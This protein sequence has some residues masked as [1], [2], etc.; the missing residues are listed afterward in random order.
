MYRISLSLLIVFAFV[1]P[2][3]AQVAER[4]DPKEEAEALRSEA[5]AFLRETMGDAANMR[6]LENRISFSAEMAGL[7][8]HVDEREARVMFNSA[9]A[10][11]RE[12]LT[13]LEYQLNEFPDEE[14]PTYRGGLLGDVSGRAKVEMKYRTAMGVR[15]QIASSIAEHDPEVALAFFYDTASTNPKRQENWMRDANFESSLIG[16][17]AEKQPAKAVQYGMRSLDRGFNYQHVEL[18]RRIYAKDPEKGA[19]FGVRIIDKIRTPETTT[20]VDFGVRELLSY[21]VT[22]LDQARN[23]PGRQPVFTEAQLREVAESYAAYMLR[24]SEKF[25]ASTALSFASTIERISPVR[26]AQLKAR[27]GGGSSNSGFGGGAPPPP[28]SRASSAANVS[29]AE[30]EAGGFGTAARPG[31]VQTAEEKLE[32]DL[33]GLGSGSLPKEERDRVI[34]EARKILLQT[35]GREK[36]ITGLSML[37]GQVAKA[38]DKELAAEIM[39]DAERLV[40]PSPKNYQDFLLTW[41]LASGYADADPEK[42]FPILDD[43]I[44]RANNIISAAV[45]VGE[46]VDAMEEIISDGEIQLGGFGG[47]ALRGLSRQLGVAEA[48]ID[49][50]ARADFA[51]TKAL[52]NRFERPEVRVLAKM[53]VLRTVLGKKSLVKSPEQMVEQADDLRRN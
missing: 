4:K 46:F 35:Q 10:D 29:L 40:N 45:Q 37:A 16:E 33:K 53:L 48:T 44:G 20:A 26:A 30:G 28:R 25:D 22:A 14:G 8:W 5:V 39:R 52:T 7:M 50:L 6:T 24:P 38:G 34:G 3:A 41:M 12:L 15:Q 11:F 49:R 18:L 51:R 42:A 1:C 2:I 9:I 27:Y 23:Q 36:Q 17:I 21:G 32:K 43:A 31:G 19:E 47:G 13:R